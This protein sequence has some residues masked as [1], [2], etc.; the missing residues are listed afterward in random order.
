MADSDAKNLGAGPPELDP[1][2]FE[3]PLVC[4]DCSRTF[5]VPYRHFEAGVVF[6][7]PHCRG[8]FV[9]KTTM[10]RLVKDAVEG[11]RAALR[12]SAASDTPTTRQRRYD[13]LIRQLERLANEMRPAGKMVRPKGWRAMFT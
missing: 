13:G 7:C 5:K 4:K 11:Y 1:M 3:I 9:P 10:C 12:E 6:H 8:S 2:T